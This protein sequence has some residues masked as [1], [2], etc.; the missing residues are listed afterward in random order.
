[1]NDPGSNQAG[2][3]VLVVDDEQ[4]FTSVLEKVLRRRSFEVTTVGDGQSALSAFTP[5]RFD[6]VLLDLKMPGGLD[7]LQVLEELRRRDHELPVIL[8]TGHRAPDQEDDLG[9]R[10]F[11]LV[12]KPH[13]IPDLIK[14]IERAVAG[15]NGG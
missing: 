9:A 1:M 10:A 13:P 6:V 3:R 2:T 7:G 15:R 11:A 5:G 14:L 4:E 8:M 12:L